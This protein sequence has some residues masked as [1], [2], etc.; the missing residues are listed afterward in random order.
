MGQSEGEKQE[1]EGRQRKHN[2][3][4]QKEEAAPGQQ[5]WQSASVG[6]RGG[7]WCRCNS[8]SNDC[9]EEESPGRDEHRQEERPR[10]KTG[11]DK[12]TRQ[13]EQRVRTQSSMRQEE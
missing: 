7:G 6:R 4:G 8:N 3:M 2:E 1:Q 9:R 11:E 10:T 13:Q 5:G 12:R